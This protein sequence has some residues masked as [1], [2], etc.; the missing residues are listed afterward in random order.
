MRQLLLATRNAHKTREFAEI[1]GGEFSVRD[2][3]EM[4]EAPAVLESGTTFAENAALKAM[5]ASTHC[6]GLVVADD[7]GLEVEALNG[8]PGVYSARYAGEGATDGQNVAKLLGELSGLT[9]ATLWTARFRCALALAR[10]GRVVGMF[11]GVVKGTIVS[12]SRGMG[13]FGYDPIFLPDGFKQTFA[14]LPLAEKNRISHRARAVESLRAML[15]R[16]FDG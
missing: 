13:G 16:G 4:P 6:R 7:S 12:R 10:Q 2:L 1:L 5:A 8:R 11:D 14:E 15:A 9:E 3:S